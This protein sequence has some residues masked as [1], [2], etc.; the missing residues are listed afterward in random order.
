MIAVFD[1]DLRIADLRFKN[2]NIEIGKEVSSDGKDPIYNP[3]M[4]QEAGGYEEKLY[5]I[6]RL[7]LSAGA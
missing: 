7:L 5:G 3:F 6:E 4:S 2:L 1:P